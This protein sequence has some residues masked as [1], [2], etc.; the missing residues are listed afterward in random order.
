VGGSLSGD[1]GCWSGDVEGSLSGDVG[2]SLS[3]DVG[4]WSGDVGGSLSGDVGGSLSGDAGCCSGDVGCW[5]DPSFVCLLTY[6]VF[7][8]WPVN[9]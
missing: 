2:G 4:C 1:V 8:S 9:W 7:F 5:S 3:G 6:N